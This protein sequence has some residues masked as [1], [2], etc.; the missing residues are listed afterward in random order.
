M[1]TLK[2]YDIIITYKMFMLQQQLHLRPKT[3]ESTMDP[4]A[5]NQGQPHVILFAILS[6]LESL[7]HQFD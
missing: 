1:I 6:Y 3:L 7:C 4:Q 2:A 5:G